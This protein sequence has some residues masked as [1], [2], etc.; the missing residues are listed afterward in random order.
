MDQPQSEDEVRVVVEALRRL[1]HL[2]DIVWNPEAVC[3]TPASFD[4]R[5]SARCATYD[6]RWQ[7]VRRDT[8]SKLRDDR[9]YA[10]IL[11]VTAPDTS[12]KY[13]IMRDGGA[14]APIGE[15]LVSYMALWDR[16]N[17]AWIG[18][19][20]ELWKDHERAE[21]WM[22]TDETEGNQDALEKIYR[23]HGGQYW[24]GGAQGRTANAPWLGASATAIQRATGKR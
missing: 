11:T 23:A 20:D 14:Y 12:G 1:D 24:M 4:V 6:G 2:L 15:W 17:S 7:V 22:R 16:A 21:S 10:V 8:G 9:D 19:M 5:G 18:A 3:S 13:P